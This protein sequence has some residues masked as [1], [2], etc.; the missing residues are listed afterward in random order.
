MASRLRP[1]SAEWEYAT[2]QAEA[3]D[4]I[5]VTA[6]TI[7]EISHGL[8]KAARGGVRPAVGHLHWLRGQLEAGV[9]I[10]LAFE[11]RAAEVAGYLRAAHPAAPVGEPG[12]SAGPSR[13]GA[14]RG[15][16]TSRSRPPRGLMV[17]ASSPQT[18]ISRCS[19]RH[20]TQPRPV[21][22]HSQSSIQPAFSDE[23]MAPLSASRVR[24]SKAACTECCQGS[25][26]A[27]VA[28]AL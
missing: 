26:T 13:S 15:S 21:H 24:R 8:Q 6:T 17:T 27:R 20:S 10:A 23:T 18:L 14:W 22:H 1:D 4:P 7:F 11:S 19:P 28:S 2:R 5:A 3:G 16:S 25:G 12:P 9:I